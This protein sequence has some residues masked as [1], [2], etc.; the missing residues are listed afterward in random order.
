M[1]R[2]ITI[3]LLIVLI[4]IQ[5]IR[6]PKNESGDTTKDVGG[7]FKMS[8]EVKT[9]FQKAC[10]DCHSN[11]T[12]YPWY[13]NVQPFA[14][15]IAH[16]VDEGKEHLNLNAFLNYRPNRQY[17]KLEEIVETLDENSMPLS[18]YTLIHK[19]ARLT[20]VQKQQIMAWANS[21]MDSMK[22]WYPTDSL[23]M[24]KRNKR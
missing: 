15:W 2:R 12:E 8:A 20:E 7:K 19:E 14:W 10:N 3:I 21:A 5:F 1:I 6:P 23:K 17:H 13:A 4:L 11:K 24:P 18:S 22:V 16:H 9:L